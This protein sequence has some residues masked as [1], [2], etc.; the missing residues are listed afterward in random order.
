MRGGGFEL[1][2]GFRLDA[3]K[4]VPLAFWADFNAELSRRGAG[5]L[6]GELLDGDAAAVSRT[7]REGRFTAMFDFPLGFAIA[8]VFCR[9]QPPA[10]L[11]SALT[12]DRRYPDPAML[13]TLVDNHDLPRV[14]SLC[15]GDPRR[16]KEALAFLLTGRGIPSLSWGTEIGATG[17]AEP[18]NRASMR[19]EASPLRDEIAYWLSLRRASP[20]LADGAPVVLALDEGHLALGRATAGQLAVV[21][22]NRTAEP[23]APRLPPPWRDVAWQSA[24]GGGAAPVGRGV[25]VWLSELRDGAW[26]GLAAAVDR[27]WRTGAQRRVVQLDGLPADALVVGSGEELGDWRPAAGV[28]APRL[29]LPVGGVFEFKLVRLVKGAPVWEAGANRVLWV[30]PG[31]GPLRVPL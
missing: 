3:V 25:T 10:R 12:D 23:W 9:D 8:D 18:E 7:W 26:A 5:L 20:A 24:R 29:E 17:E 11:A 14:M 19:F 1:A 13:V 16:V 4:H 6:L 22:V 15:K 2:D 28:S 31:E 27:Q 30:E 21:L